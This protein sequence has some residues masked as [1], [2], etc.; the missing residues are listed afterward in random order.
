MKNLRLVAKRVLYVSKL[1]NVNK[2]KIRIILSVILANLIVA[3]DIGIIVIFS[4]LLTNAVN[5]DNLIVVFITEGIKSNLFLIPVIIVLRYL[6]MFADRMNMEILSLQVNENLR[7]HLL[8]EMYKKG[9]YSTSD[10]YY[11][12]NTV[13]Q[14]VSAFYKALSG[15]LNNLLQIIGYSI[16]LIY[17][18][19]EMVMYFLIGALVLVFPTKYLLSKGKSYQHLSFNTGK[20]INSYIQRVLDNI[21][22]IKILETRKEEFDKF[23]TRLE[24][25]KN[26]WIKNNIFG[27][28]NSMLPSFG[29]LFFLSLILAFF[30]FAKNLTIEFI[31]VLLRMFQS[32]GNFNNTLTLVVNSSVHV[33]ELYKIEENKSPEKNNFF[34]I[35]SNLQNAV[36]VKELSFKYFGSEENIFSNIN[37]NFKKNSHTVITG[38]NG[39]GKSTLLGLIAGLY[40]PQYGNVSIYTDKIG[41]VGVNPLIISGSLRENL[42]YGNKKDISDNEMYKLIDK[43]LLFEEEE[44]DLTKLISI[45]NLSSG[46]MQKIS[47]MRALLNDV[48]LLI[49]DESTSNLDKRTKDLIFDILEKKHLTIINSTHNEED[50]NFDRHLNI[51]IENSQRKL[52]LN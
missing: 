41:Y 28:L 2:K 49:L 17:S 14:N 7:Y 52:N 47:F 6:I 31:G 40:I 29:T 10:A 21:F 15:F 51:I 48:E 42:I 1:T 50:F 27:A 9:N 19:T 16:F 46:Q 33:D 24:K 11:Y 25:N 4:A 30:D 37:I 45:K 38:P 44:F 3:I 36:E 26:A 22:L 18:D 39:S 12:L 13:S 5:N 23:Q 8:N 20:D 43:F 35:N 34:S 32:L